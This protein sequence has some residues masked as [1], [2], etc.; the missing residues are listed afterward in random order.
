MARKTE[1]YTWRV[2]AAMKASLEEAARETRRSVA[3][4]LEAIVMEHL[5]APDHTGR[6]D[7]EQQRRLHTRTARFLGSLA[8]GSA[9]R[10]ERVR[11]L[12]RTRLKRRRDADAR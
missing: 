11:Q 8:G 7:I 10:S 9:R 1:V 4:L 6:S 12:V 5:S 3:Q 2:S